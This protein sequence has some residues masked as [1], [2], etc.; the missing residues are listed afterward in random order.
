MR[1]S[2]LI[3]AVW[4]LAGFLLA[5]PEILGVRS[6]ASFALPP[7]AAG[8]IV[9]IFGRGMEEPVRVLFDGQ[10][11]QILH[12]RETQIN[13]VVPRELAGRAS[14]LLELESS[15]TKSQGFLLA[16]A[17][18]APGVFTLDS[19]GRGPSAA[20][21]QD[22]SVNG[23][24]NPA[25]DETIV[26][27]FVTG[28]GV[29]PVQVRVEIAGGPAEV[30]YAG[31]APGQAPGLDQVNF[32][33][34]KASAFGE[35]PVVLKAAGR[36][37][38]S[39]A[40][41]AV[42]LGAAPADA[43]SSIDNGVIRVGAHLDL[44]GAIT[45]LSQSDSGENVINSYDYGRQVQQSYYSGPVPF[46]DPHPNWRQLGWNPI[47]TGD[48]YKNKSKV[49]A[50]FNDRSVSYTRTNPLHWPLNNVPCECTFET[51]IRL[52]GRSA[53]VEAKLRNARS[54]T[55]WYQ[56]RS[57][58]LPAVYTTG[59]YHR[60]FTYDGT[61]PFSGAPLREIIQ[62]GP[63]WT[64]WFSS[65]AWA[66]YVNDAGFGLGVYHPGVHRIS[67]GF[68]GRPNTGGPNDP[69]T[70]YISPNL[71]E[72][73][74]HNIEY[75]YAFHLILGTLA[76]IRDFVYG[77]RPDPKPEYIFEKDRQHWYYVNARDTGFPIE[78]KLRVMLDRN[79]PYMIGPGGMWRAE[80]VPKLYIRAAYRTSNDNAEVFWSVPGE[81][82]RA[83][84]SVRFR[85]TAD[86][87]YRT[88][89]VDL[90]SSPE[91]KGWITGVRFDPVS[92]GVDGDF[93]DIKWIS[94]RELEP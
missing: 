69:S 41:L 74:D 65:E 24:A 91:Y 7:V 17:P 63:P 20:L 29:D 33:L 44:G 15:G 10:P 45:Y 1:L 73:I 11:A 76:E 75:G 80:D 88:Y 37:S 58:E 46:G 34:P 72:V 54:D 52:E 87:V 28:L 36:E 53:R 68:A 86:S 82:F 57:Q 48:V 31:P 50:H 23:A 67:G 32:R 16:L 38:Q 25:L 2:G 3:L 79:D 92:S 40:L 66:A 9:A 59:K 83:G 13:A 43:L 56:A 12:V 22:N 61:E 4:P 8:A 49:V 19:S 5:A 81:S 35:L 89:E 30:L 71:P 93:V 18:A 47:G 77:R 51:W 78:G 14:T 55:T 94:H 21:N 85:A 62:A 39:F 90:A 64:T 60:L 27:L 84:R 42:R 26:Q 70:G 6:A